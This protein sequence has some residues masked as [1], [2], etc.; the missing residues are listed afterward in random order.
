MQLALG[1]EI[2]GKMWYMCVCFLARDENLWPEITCHG[3]GG[4]AE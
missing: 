1:Q 3:L 2:Y 4:I